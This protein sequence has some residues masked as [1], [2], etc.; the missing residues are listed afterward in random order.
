MKEIQPVP[1]W[2]NGEM[3]AATLFNMIS[4]NDNL[5]NEC[6]FYYQLFSIT[7]IQ[8]AQG[9]ITMTATDYE[10]YSSSPDSNTYAYQW[11]ATQLKLTLV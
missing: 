6:I 2:Y 11:G 7:N 4:I 10:T 8:L 1:N 3:I 5:T 9:N